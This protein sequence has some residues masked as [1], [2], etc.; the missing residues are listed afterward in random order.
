MTALPTDHWRD[1]ATA[2]GARLFVKP[3]LA[4]PL[5]WVWHRAMF[6]LAGRFRPMAPGITR[7]SVTLGGRPGLMFAPRAPDRRLMW[8]HG[9]GFCVGSP[10]TYT[11]LLSHLARKANAVVLAPSYRLAPEHRFPAACD[12]VDAALIDAEAHRPDL[13]PLF[14]GGDSAGGCLVLGAMADGLA[15]GQR[16]GA[17]LLASPAGMIDVTRPVPPAN[18]YLFPVSILRRIARDYAA[19]HDPANPRL[20]PVHADF[21]GA[22]PALIHC[23]RGEL[24]E[25]DSDAIAESLRAAGGDVTVEKA[26]RMVHAW[27]FLA[28]SLPVADIAVARMADFLR[29]HS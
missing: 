20:S 8:V 3:S 2:H 27:H 28:G 24:L 12:D 19:G 6:G 11:G 9:G 29:A 13:G 25:E 14:L 10:R 1:R 17:L 15:R 21:T 26:R 22:P 4:L 7:K 5:P 23:A 18:D 16:Y